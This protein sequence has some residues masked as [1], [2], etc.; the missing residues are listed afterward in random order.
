M[1]SYGLGRTSDL[2]TMPVTGTEWEMGRPCAT[3][4]LTLILVKSSFCPDGKL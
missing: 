1:H 2:L 3:D 4:L